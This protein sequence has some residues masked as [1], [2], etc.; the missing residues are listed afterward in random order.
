MGTLAAVKFAVTIVIL[1][2][3]ACIVGTLL[4][5]GTDVTRYLEVHPEAAN[6]MEWL[7]RLGLTDVFYSKWFVGLLG[8]LAAS[9][10]T[11]S[12]RR[13]AT[14]RRT[15]GLVR[16]RAFGSMITH[17][18]MLLILLG[19]IVRGVWGEKGYIE[20]RQGETKDFFVLENGAK[21]LPFSLHLT[22]FEL[23]P[24]APQTADAAASKENES[25]LTVLWSEQNVTA[26][27]PIKL[28]VEQTLAPKDKPATAENTYR[29]KILR[30]VPDFTV[31]TQTRQVSSRSDEPN[32]PALQIAV[33]GPGGSNHRWLF[34]KFPEFGQEGTHN[35]KAGSGLRM[36]FD[37][38]GAP[39]SMPKSIKN[40]KSTVRI[41][42]GDRDLGERI[43]RVNSPFTH[44]GYSFFQSGYNPR[45]LG[46]TSLQVVRDP[47]VP[48]VYAGF[49][50]MLAGLSIA[51][52]V[53]AKMDAQRR[54]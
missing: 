30:Y 28:D 40:F 12:M 1:L 6:K 14:V 22:R 33:S 52:Y 39:D 3:V 36:K 49:A 29:I 20:L 13:F 2:T 5:Q 48:V 19:G 31:D 25:R 44:K 42:E 7:S 50:L 41:L 43:V 54:A 16:M 17:I 10:A 38:R 15:T 34:A 45:D 21:P 8:L 27:F 53:G 11:C 35:E 18:S 51:F 24:D 9:V 46:W 23:E 26:H 4:P 37:F 32:N 47:G